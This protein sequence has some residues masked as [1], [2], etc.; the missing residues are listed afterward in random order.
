[1]LFLSDVHGATSALRRLVDFGE[2]IAVLGD[3]ANLTDYR[4]GEGAVADVLGITFARA[5]SSARGEGDFETMRSLWRREVGD[6]GE[7][8]R[9]AIG[10]A[11]ERQYAE[12]AEALEGGSGLVIHGNVDRPRLLQKAL[13]AGY[14]YLQGETVDIDGVLFGFVGGGVSTPLQA[15]GE[16][17]DEEVSRMLGEMGPVEVL[18]THVPPALRPLRLDVITGREERGSEP[19][20]EYLL[21]HRPRL[22]MFGDIHQAQATT[23]RIGATRCVNTG[24]FRATGRYLRVEGTVVRSGRVG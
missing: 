9:V 12:V 21:E 1:M 6:R 5:A 14:R 19:V 13:P 4:S 15:E 23:W 18:C 11:L 16:V 17:S 24:Y 7:E 3:L 2:P 22:H 20:L 8:V 10:D